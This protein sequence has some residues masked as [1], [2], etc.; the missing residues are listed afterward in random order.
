MLILG[1]D[2]SIE[3]LGLFEFA[4]AVV[5]DGLFQQRLHLN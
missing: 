3:H 5:R 1:N 4:C 2:L